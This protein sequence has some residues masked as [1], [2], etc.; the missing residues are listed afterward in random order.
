MTSTNTNDQNPPV[1][2]SDKKKTVKKQGGIIRWGGIIPLVL[3]VLLSYAYFYFFFDSHVR[4]LIEWGGYQ[5]LGSEVNV[6]KFRSS[7]L[8][9]QFQVSRLQLT[10]AESPDFNSIEISEIRFDLNMDALLRLKFV[11]E[12]MGVDGIQFASKR[13]SRGKVAPPPP[14][15]PNKP[16]LVSQLS[17]AALDKTEDKYKNNLL[18][19]IASFLKTGGS[20]QTQLDAI[21]STLKSKKLAEDLKSKWDA[22]KIDWD[23]KI[24][25]LP[26][27]S[28]LKSIKTRFDGIQYKNFKNVQEVDSAV[29]QFNELK[30]DVDTKVKLIDQTKTTLVSD[31]NAIQSDVKLIDQEIKNDINNLKDRLKIPKLDAA[32]I[33]KS[34][35]MDYLNPYLAKIDKYKT[36]AQKYLPPRFANMLESDSRKKQQEVLAE[37]KLIP[38]PRENGVTYEFPKTTGYPMFWIKT[39]TISSKSNAQ[40][41]LGDIAGKVTDITSNQRQIRKTTKFDVRGDFKS[42]GLL[43]VVSTGELNNLGEEPIADVSF[44]FTKYELTN[45]KLLSSPDGTIEIPKTSTALQF[46]GKTIGFKD[47]QVK[48]DYLFSDVNFASSAQDQTVATILTETLQQINQFDVKGGITGAINAPSLSLNSS[49]GSQL[50]T[51]FQNLLKAK[52]EEANKKLQAEIDKQIGKLKAD[53]EGI[54]SNLTAQVN[55][56][57]TAAKD[58]LDNQKKQADTRI[59]EAKKD[60]ENQAK[61]KLQQDGQKAIDDLKK[62]LGF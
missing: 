62:K 4:K 47:I 3:F 9:G 7:F 11:I 33:A 61:G 10:D 26:T 44:K 57:V 12:D 36:L 59:A 38:H 51:A 21:E 18:G 49:L 22:K 13:R 35:F 24:K 17:G 14:V 40:S 39:V 28:D 48:F 52:I 37:E 20:G 19:D 16:S 54:K 29:K 27:E 42:K 6:D 41:D 2:E 34:M 32:S 60:L 5:A 30:A 58:Q 45:L 55:T 46:Q 15:D 31:V 25:E 23:S 50:E 53:I 56:Q 43:G 1:N 8:K